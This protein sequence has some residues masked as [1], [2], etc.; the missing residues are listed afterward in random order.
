MKPLVKRIC[1]ECIAVGVL[2]GKVFSVFNEWVL[3]VEHLYEIV[4]DYEDNF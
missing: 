2:R 4:D 1:K 3:S